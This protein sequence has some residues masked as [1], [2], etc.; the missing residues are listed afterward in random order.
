M[1][2]SKE[3]TLDYTG[4]EVT[5]AL[6]V[7]AQSIIEAYV[8]KAEGEVDNASDLTKLG[9]AVAYQ[10]AYMKDNPARVFEQMAVNQIGQFGQIM[11]FRA[12]Q[13]APFIAPLAFYTCKTLSWRKSRS[14]K[15]GSIFGGFPD[16]A[17]ARWFVE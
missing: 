2:V 16:S 7:Q 11:S 10:A 9:K 15:T 14:V 3:Q 5:S 12:D 17:K 1:F 13:P 8:G 4:Y 6:L